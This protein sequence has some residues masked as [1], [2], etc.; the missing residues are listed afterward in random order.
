VYAQRV[1]RIFAGVA[2]LLVINPSMAVADAP[3]ALMLSTQVSGDI[4]DPESWLPEFD[5]RVTKAAGRQGV[6]VLP[7]RP[8][9]ESCREPRCLEEVAARYGAD[10]VV[11]PSVVLDGQVPPD[12]HLTVLVYDAS[13]RKVRRESEVC[14]QCYE[15]VAADTLFRAA[16]KAFSA[17]VEPPATAPALAAAPAPAPAP[18]P[19]APAA[20]PNG[21]FRRTL[22]LSIG[23]AAAGGLA[24]SVIGLAVAAAEDGQCARSVP[25]EVHCPIRKNDSGGIV[26]G[27]L[28]TAAFAAIAPT[29]F[30]L[31]YRET[32][33]TVSRAWLAPILDS[34][35]AGVAVGGGF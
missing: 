6:T 28:L 35:R 20:P 25:A 24:G 15:S 12:Y 33:K 10:L 32:K 14:H 17:P 9:G 3:R 30:Y 1:A 19:P 23:V 13:K 31:Y 34:N 2:A 4:T 7:V 5:R 27:S 18:A 26:A 29:F 11:V 21:S 16:G 22:Y 8:E